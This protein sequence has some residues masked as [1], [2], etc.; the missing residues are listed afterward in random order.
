MAP[1][2]PQQKK[3]NV[4]KLVPITENLKKN[5]K[6]IYFSHV[7]QQDEHNARNSGYACCF[8]FTCSQIYSK[9]SLHLN[10]RRHCAAP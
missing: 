7:Q 9:L 2:S 10:Y 4:P 6:H 3:K 8:H 1:L 5:T